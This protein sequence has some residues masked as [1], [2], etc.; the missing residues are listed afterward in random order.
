VLPEAQLD[1]FLM[2]I[3]V[4]YPSADAEAQVLRTEKDTAT[5]EHLSPVMTGQELLE[6]IEFV[7]QG[8]EVAPAIENYIVSLCAHTRTL[9]EVRLGVS[10][11]GGLA[12]LRASRVAA[13]AAGRAYI[14]PDDVKAMAQATLA[15][16]IILRPDAEVQGRTAGE[17]V[18]RA[19]QAVPVPRTLV[20]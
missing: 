16:R 1:R 15:H 7:K 2:R 3:E 11:R 8:V 19:L 12:L 13:A 6:M 18:G 5:V 17:V 10:P 14:T 20:R 4:G 9:P